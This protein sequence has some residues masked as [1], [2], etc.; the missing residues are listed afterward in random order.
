MLLTL[1]ITSF[2]FFPFEFKFL[3]GANTKMILAGIGLG[4]LGLNLARQGRSQADRHF[5]MLSAWAVVV[6]F[7]AFAAVTLNET[8]DYTYVTYIVSM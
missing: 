2:Y 8:R 6:S 7:F 4:L 3:P 1:V 5:L